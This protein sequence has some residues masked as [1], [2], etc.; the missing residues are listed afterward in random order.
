MKTKKSAKKLYGVYFT[1]IVIT[2][3]IIIFFLDLNGAKESLKVSLKVLISVIPIL[4]VAILFS[5]LINY[6]FKA[7]KISKYFNRKSGIKGWAVVSVAGII[8]HGPPYVWF[9]LIKDL[10]EKGMST[11]IAAVFFYNRAIKIPLLPM[12]IF[13]F[14]LKFTIVLNLFIL[15]TS[16][17]VWKIMNLFNTDFLNEKVSH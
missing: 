1:L 8:S 9:Q 2:I 16:F 3:Y 11:G 17:L 4:F 5:S 15:I 10:R 6:F 14:G 7:K 12:M 13:Y